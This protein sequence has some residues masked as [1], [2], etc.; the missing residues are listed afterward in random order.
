[1]DNLDDLISRKRELLNEIG[2]LGAF[3]RGSIIEQYLETRRKD[4]SVVRN[5]PYLLYSFKDKAQ[6]TVARRIQ[7]GAEENR[8][9]REIEAFRTYEALSAELV[10]I[11][12]R[13]CDAMTVPA[14][15]RGEVAA[16]KKLRNPSSK[17]SGAKSKG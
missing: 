9:R 8:Y 17:R 10:D 15:S 7:R 3:R 16:E 4:G 1:M 12:H 13:I 14:G 5:G 2:R 6:K 11:S